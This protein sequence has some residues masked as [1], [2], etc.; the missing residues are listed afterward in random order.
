MTQATLG[1]GTK[2]AY[3]TTIG[4]SPL[5]YTDV[6]EVGDIPD[7]VESR[8]FVEATNQDSPG[9]TREYIPALI[10]A[11]E[12]EFEMNYLPNNAAQDAL[13]DMKTEQTPRMWEIRETTVSP[14][15]VWSFLAYV[16][17]HSIA[18]PV[19]DKKMRKIT[20]RRTGPVTV[21]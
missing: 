17:K 14:V 6:P 10:D 18:A 12:V 15:R 8:E 3:E 21:S 11:E 2:L 7:L 20:L 4:A 9:Y 5:V 16:S 1:I 13:K 19:A